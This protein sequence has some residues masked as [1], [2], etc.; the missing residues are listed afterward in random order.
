LTLGTPGPLRLTPSRLSLV[1]RTLYSTSALVFRSAFLF[2]PSPLPRSRNAGCSGRAVGFPTAAQSRQRPHLSWAEQSAAANSS[3]S[4]G[5]AVGFPPARTS[6]RPAEP[7]SRWR[8][9]GKEWARQITTSDGLGVSHDT[10]RETRGGRAVPYVAGQTAALFPINAPHSGDPGRTAGT[11]CVSCDLEDR[12]TGP[13]TKTRSESTSTPCVENRLSEGHSH[14][15]QQQLACTTPQQSWLAID[16][17]RT[18]G[19]YRY[20]F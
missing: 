14:H 11:G 15:H 1:A 8:G 13:S 4:L 3:V 2:S 16:I 10:S 19:R 9:T 20:A 18:L 12:A 6:A 7:R 17:H 5:H